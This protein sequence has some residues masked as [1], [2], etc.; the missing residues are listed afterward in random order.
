MKTFLDRVNFTLNNVC[1]NACLLVSDRYLELKK[2][3]DNGCS[4][5]KDSD[6][7]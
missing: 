7:V 3:G 2:K 6:G 4:L 5:S 1:F